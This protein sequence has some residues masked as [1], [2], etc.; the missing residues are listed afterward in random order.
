[1]QDI[2][3]RAVY[4]LDEAGYWKRLPWVAGIYFDIVM[5]VFLGL[6]LPALL[7]PW[8]GKRDSVENGT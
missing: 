7:S 6:L 4:D 1:M 2:V 5:G 3:P 8:E